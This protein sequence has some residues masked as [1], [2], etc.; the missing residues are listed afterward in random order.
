MHKA[1]LSG[2]IFQYSWTK[3]S[4][5]DAL[6]AAGN[7]FMSTN[8]AGQMVIQLDVFKTKRGYSITNSARDLPL[9]NQFYNSLEAHSRR[10]IS[11]RE[12]LFI[13]NNTNNLVCK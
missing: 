1:I 12:A 4:C 5:F 6:T 13:G 8:I 11:A 2:C 3:G 9:N 10:Q 7:S